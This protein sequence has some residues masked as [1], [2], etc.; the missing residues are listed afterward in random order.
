MG[1]ARG[2]GVAFGRGVK[3]GAA[4]LL[5][6]MA[7]DSI[8]AERAGTSDTG[9]NLGREG[10]AKGTEELTDGEEVLSEYAPCGR[11]AANSLE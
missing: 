2:R 7:S 11:V 4:A 3:L 9:L 8:A 6:T 1:V 10:V 5:V